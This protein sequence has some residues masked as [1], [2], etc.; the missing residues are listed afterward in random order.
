MSYSVIISNKKITGLEEAVVT[1]P[2][3]AVTLSMLQDLSAVVYD[4][5]GYVYSIDLNDVLTVGNDASGLSITNFGS[6]VTYVNKDYSMPLNF[7]FGLGMNAIERE[8]QQLK[9][10]FA[11][12]KPSGG[13]TKMNCGIEWNYKNHVFLRGG[14]R[15][16]HALAT[17][18]AGAGVCMQLGNINFQFDYSISDYSQF[19]FVNRFG[20]SLQF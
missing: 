9:I 3:D 19:G 11:A 8:D 10:S 7:S 4:L 1:Q 5:S 14:Y 13:E 17:Y 20:L 15:F 2:N 12:I 16:N 6:S 18:S